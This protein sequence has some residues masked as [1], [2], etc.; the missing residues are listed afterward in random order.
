MNVELF[1]VE[2]KDNHGVYL[3]VTNLI[4]K[5]EQMKILGRDG[6]GAL[7]QHCKC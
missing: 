1:V 5:E 7:Y 4:S 3:K 2:N 6:I